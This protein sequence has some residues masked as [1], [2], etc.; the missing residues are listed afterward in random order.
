MTVLAVVALAGI[1][2]VLTRIISKPPAADLVFSCPRDE[3]AEEVRNLLQ[4]HG[5]PSY[6]KN[7]GVSRLI[8]SAHDLVN[9]TVHVVHSQDRTR[10][11]EIIEDWRLSR[12]RGKG[13]SYHDSAT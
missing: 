13:G 7:A 12:S 10:A 9:P 3:D 5:I 2:L 8:P 11:R 4:A 1:A 6:V